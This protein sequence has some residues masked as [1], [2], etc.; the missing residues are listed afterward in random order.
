MPNKLPHPSR[1]GDEKEG[2]QHAGF[3]FDR[4]KEGQPDLPLSREE[5]SA[6]RLHRLLAGAG[7]CTRNLKRE[8]VE[9]DG[10]EYV[11]AVR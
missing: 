11:D 8:V 6:V 2:Q 9:H 7:F 1:D 4:C 5:V 10:F 3:P